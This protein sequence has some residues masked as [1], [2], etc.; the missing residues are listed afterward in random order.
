MKTPQD[1]LPFPHEESQLERFLPYHVRYVAGRQI[2]QPGVAL[3]RIEPVPRIYDGGRIRPA[4]DR[5][6][7][8]E[9]GGGA[10]NVPV[11]KVGFQVLAKR[12]SARLRLV[13]RCRHPHGS[14]LSTLGLPPPKSPRNPA[15]TRTGATRCRIAER[16]TTSPARIA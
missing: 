11:L 15:T 12:P 2:H 10:K 3:G 5:A 14:H 8:D 13:N 4:I 1:V 9:S 16:S 6:P 7:H